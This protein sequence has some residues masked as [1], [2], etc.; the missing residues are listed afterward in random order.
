MLFT[1]LKQKA[2]EKKLRSVDI[3][4]VFRHCFEQVKNLDLKKSIKDV[5]FIVFDTEA[6]GLRPKEGD[7]L[8]SIGAIGVSNGRV[9]LSKSFYELVKPERNIPHHSVVVHNLTPSK[10]KGLP[11]VSD[12]LARFFEFCKGDILV[13]HHT[14]FDIRF[15]DLALK[16]NFGI[17]LANRVLDTAMIARCIQRIED[18]GKVAMEET[19]TVHLDGLAKR[20]NIKMPDR[21]DAYGDAFA[22]ALIFQRQISLLYKEGISLLKDLLRIGGVR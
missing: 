15:L 1:Y 8:L 2:Y 9:D 7:V 22:T 3:P 16:E 19:R 10:L 14:F 11:P 18:P 20:F 5:E 12:V 6:T 13:G 17:T 4:D 21:H